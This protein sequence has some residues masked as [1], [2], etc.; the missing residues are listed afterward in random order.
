[1]GI[2]KPL[3]FPIKILILLNNSKIVS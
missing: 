2:H 3:A 1:M